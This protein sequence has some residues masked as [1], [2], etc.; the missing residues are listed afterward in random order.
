MCPA[1]EI[2]ARLAILKPTTICITKKAEIN[3]S[4]VFRVFFLLLLEDRMVSN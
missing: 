4:T 1:S 3:K 2:T